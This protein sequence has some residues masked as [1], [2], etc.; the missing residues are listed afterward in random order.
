MRWGV[1]ALSYLTALL[2]GFLVSWVLF[3]RYVAVD[4]ATGVPIEIEIEQIKQEIQAAQDGK[5]PPSAAPSANPSS[6][7]PPASS[8]PAPPPESRKTP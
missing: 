8:K 2:L 3:P 7:A 4:P 1:T 6:G 5:T